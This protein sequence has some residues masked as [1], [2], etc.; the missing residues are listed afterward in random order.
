MTTALNSEGIL[1]P[2]RCSQTPADQRRPQLEKQRE[3]RRWRN[4]SILLHATKMCSKWIYNE[5]HL[6]FTCIES[7]HPDTK[8]TC[9]ISPFA[10]L[11]VTK[12]HKPPAVGWQ[13]Q[14]APFFPV[15]ACEN[16][17]G[18]IPRH[19]LRYKPTQS[20]WRV[21]SRFRCSTRLLR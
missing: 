7:T 2:G 20:A 3:K 14:C 4:H 6:P 16:F 1:S 13:Q 21:V 10:S 15:S 12:K 19:E 11:F 9:S 8:C 5:V 17:K 18:N